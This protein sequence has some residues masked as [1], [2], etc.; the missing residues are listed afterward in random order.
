MPT[1][2]DDHDDLLDAEDFMGEDDGNDS[3]ESAA[4]R[5]V[6]IAAMS[7]ATMKRFSAAAATLL[8]GK[9]GRDLKAPEPLFEVGFEISEEEMPI[10]VM[11][12]EKAGRDL[13]HVS[14]HADGSGKPMGLLA[15]VYFED[16]RARPH[17]RCSLVCAPG[18]TSVRLAGVSDLEDETCHF[19]FVP[20]GK[21]RRVPGYSL[22]DLGDQA[23]RAGHMWFARA[24]DADLAASE[25][26]RMS[27]YELVEADVDLAGGDG[28]G[29]TSLH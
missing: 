28:E 27:I 10:L 7:G 16:G 25:D 18:S 4:L 8:A 6:V 22:D 9:S 17:R 23:D 5:R 26:E 20:G 21:M 2:K 11:A 15:V 13:I 24:D 3:Q 14:C 19:E 1:T 29:S 12:A